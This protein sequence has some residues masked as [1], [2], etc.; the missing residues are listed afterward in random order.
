MWENEGR[1]KLDKHKRY[2]IDV[3]VES[4]VNVCLCAVCDIDF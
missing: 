4:C 3:R 2:C 1:S